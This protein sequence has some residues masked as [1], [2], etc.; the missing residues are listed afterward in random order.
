MYKQRAEFGGTVRHTTLNNMTRPFLLLLLFLLRRGTKTVPSFR[1]GPA[2]FFSGHRSPLFPGFAS[3]TTP[4]E[5]SPP[6][7]PLSLPSVSLCPSTV[8][9]LH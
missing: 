3:F 6:V 7:A 2:L 5:I 9:R 8:N 4:A 1:L